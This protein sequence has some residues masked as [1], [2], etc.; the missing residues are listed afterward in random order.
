MSK[1]FN[2]AIDLVR[3]TQFRD[4]PSFESPD[5]IQINIIPV[6]GNVRNVNITKP[7]W[8]LLL[9]SA[10]IGIESS[11]DEVTDKLYNV[12][13]FKRYAKNVQQ[14]FLQ[15]HIGQYYPQY[16]HLPV[17]GGNLTGG[18]TALNIPD[19]KYMLKDAWGARGVGLIELD[20]RNLSLTGL[21]RRIKEYRLKSDN[22]PT[23]DGYRNLLKT[24]GCKF[25]EGIYRDEKEILS[26]F[27]KLEEY[28]IAQQMLDMSNYI[29]LRVMMYNC[30]HLIYTRPDL[31]TEYNGY[32]EPY[33]VPDINLV[34]IIS[35]LTAVFRGHGLVSIDLFYDVASGKWGIFE[36]QNQYGL[37]N[38][39]N[40]HHDKFIKDVIVDIVKEHLNVTEGNK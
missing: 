34:S 30:H 9:M 12:R 2:L 17:Y 8:D 36:F 29:E 5:G 6:T 28:F 33:E 26:K 24:L 13:R 37:E 39:R 35:I 22:K 21:L 16:V 15:Y 18:L 3:L 38:I 20:T 1:Q 31:D 32:G 14:D 10:N 25:H 11:N 40:D 7:F 23:V 4:I 19:G 27:E